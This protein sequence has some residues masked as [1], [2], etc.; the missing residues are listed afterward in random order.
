MQHLV[1]RAYTSLHL[2]ATYMLLVAHLPGLSRYLE[3]ETAQQ[4]LQV[5]GLWRP[6]VH[7]GILPILT[8][9]LLVCPTGYEHIFIAPDSRAT[10]TSL[11][12]KCPLSSHLLSPKCNTSS[13][14][15]DC[16]VSKSELLNSI[17]WITLFC[18]QSHWILN[19]LIKGVIA[20]YL[21]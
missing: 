13:N 18:C 17:N 6:S 19:T 12:R 5:L 7:R 3:P 16:P 1:L 4:I 8:L 21:A 20:F 9:L 15:P 14:S 2:A 10:E 11:M